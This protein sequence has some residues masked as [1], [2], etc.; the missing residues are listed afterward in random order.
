M[1]GLIIAAALSSITTA[2][3]A[4][5]LPGFR[6]SGLYDEQQMVSDNSPPGTR[7]LINAPLQ[8]F[9]EED[10]VMLIMYALPNGN[11]IEQTFGKRLNDG[12]D[13][14]YDIQH[15]GAQTRFLRKVITDRTVVVAYLENDLKSWPAWSA[16]TPEYPVKVRR[17][18]EDIKSLFAPWDPELVLN[19]HSGGGRFIFNFLDA[20]EQIPVNVVRI[21]FLDSN[22]GWE[23]ER[24][25][26]KI[27]SWL[28]SG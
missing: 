19:G 25:G 10:M 24:Y 8:G 20:Y 22:Y 12:D 1:K 3:L 15:I 21:A 4:Q 26:P 18:V 9:G 2:G 17:M 6:P 14:H 23:D 11:T 7:I 16:A 27:V 5:T 13:W 28:R